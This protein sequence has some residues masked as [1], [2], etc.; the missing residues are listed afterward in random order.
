VGGAK[1]R[2]PFP[3]CLT[4]KKTSSHT[5]SSSLRASRLLC[6][7]QF[8][9][10]R[11]IAIL[12]PEVPRARAAKSSKPPFILPILRWRERANATPTTL[13]SPN[14]FLSCPSAKTSMEI[15]AIPFRANVEGVDELERVFAQTL[16][17]KNGEKEE[18]REEGKEHRTQRPRTHKVDFAEPIGPCCARSR[19]LPRLP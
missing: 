3:L 19:L 15:H 14:S 17:A 12:L 4:P 8:Q 9:F 13:V 11:C 18:T 10:R 2:S 16:R 7:Q 6:H 1:W 5:S